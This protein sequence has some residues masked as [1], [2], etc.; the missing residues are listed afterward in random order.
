MFQ[1]SLKDLEQIV[2]KD[3]LFL[4]IK[5]N[6][7]LLNTFLSKY[8]LGL[9]GRFSA[10]WATNLSSIVDWLEPLSEES[11][12]KIKIKKLT[13]RFLLYSN[14]SYTALWLCFKCDL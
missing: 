1:Q 4:I 12:L 5:F 7:N 2:R 6:N 11:N 3:I 13:T 10:R 9:L 8:L 14:A